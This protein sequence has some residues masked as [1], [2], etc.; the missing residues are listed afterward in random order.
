MKRTL[1]SARFHW[2]A[3]L[4]LAATVAPARAQPVDTAGTVLNVLPPGQF[5]GLPFNIHTR[6]QI[7]LYDNLTPRFDAIGPTDLDLFYKQ[8]LGN[9]AGR[10]VWDDLR[11]QHDPEA[12]R[13]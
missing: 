4:V 3:T 1:G 6:D 5:G 13:S 10:A 12:P 7:P 11:E 2:L 9:T 8:R